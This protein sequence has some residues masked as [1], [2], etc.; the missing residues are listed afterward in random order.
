MKPNVASCGTAFPSSPQAMA[1]TMLEMLEETRHCR[2]LLNI[3]FVDAVTRDGRITE[4]ILSDGRKLVADYY[5]DATGDGVVC[6]AA[7]CRAMM[8]QEPASKFDELHAPPTATGKIN[9]VS[10]LYRATPIDAPHTEPLPEGVPDKCWWAGRFPV[11]SINHYPNGDLN[12]NMLPTMDG[13][14]FLRL[15]YARSLSECQRRIRAHWH[16]MQTNYAEFRAFRLSWVAPALGIRESRRI[17]GQYVLTEHDLRA[18]IN[19]QKHDDIICIAD[20]A[21][22]THGSHAHGIGELS[23]PYGVPYRCLIPQGQRNLLIACR[24]ASFSSIAA[25]SCRLSRTMMQ[26][27]QAAGTAAALAKELEVE[28]PEVPPAQLRKQLI[29]QHVQ[30]DHPMPDDLRDSLVTRETTRER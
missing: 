3:A 7:N 19:G 5:V 18:G 1:Q 14:E 2:V 15:G 29:K 6:L 30:I 21:L 8:G 11:A 9:G 22:D 17:V 20:H 4:A 24:A 10:L 27:G 25:S 26:L 12:I 23:E 16:H 28:L 13:A